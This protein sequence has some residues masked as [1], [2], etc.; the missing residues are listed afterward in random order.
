MTYEDLV[1][2]KAYLDGRLCVTRCPR[3]RCAFPTTFAAGSVCGN[4]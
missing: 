4:A 3:M 1:D 2:L